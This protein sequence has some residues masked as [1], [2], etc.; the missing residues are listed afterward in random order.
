MKSLKILLASLIMSGILQLG[1]L[2]ASYASSSSSSDPVL[3]DSPER[4]P[5][6]QRFNPVTPQQVIK[7][8][9]DRVDR[10][11][12]VP[13]PKSKSDRGTKPP[14]VLKEGE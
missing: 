2:T 9:Q 3:L 11:K 14:N 8:D 12:A 10:Y 4:S 13:A 1:W 7:K 5:D 6:R